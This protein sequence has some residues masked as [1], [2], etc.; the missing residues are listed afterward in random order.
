MNSPLRQLHYARRHGTA[1]VADEDL[2]EMDRSEL[3]QFCGTHN[4]HWEPEWDTHR[5]RREI[6][7]SI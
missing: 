2:E 3:I 5:L 6:L 1:S 4:L 7:E